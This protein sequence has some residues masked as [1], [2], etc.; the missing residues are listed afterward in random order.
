M[1]RREFLAAAGMTLAAPAMAMTARVREIASTR[2]AEVALRVG[3]NTGLV[4]VGTVGAGSRASADIMGATVNVASEIESTAQPGQVLVGGATERLVHDR[5]E[6]V[7]VPAIQVKGL[8]EPV[9]MFRVEKERTDEAASSV[10]V[11]LSGFNAPV[12]ITSPAP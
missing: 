10:E 6:L 12:N 11:D 1:D 3:V 7:S 8:S 9:L 4:M 5:F 2:N